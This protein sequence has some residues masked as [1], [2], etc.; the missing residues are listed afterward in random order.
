MCIR[1]SQKA[2]DPIDTNSATKEFF[3]GLNLSTDSGQIT[4]FASKVGVFYQDLAPFMGTSTEKADVFE[5][6]EKVYIS[7]GKFEDVF[8]NNMI[9]GVQLKKYDSKGEPINLFLQEPTKDH[10]NVFDTRTSY[11]RWSEDLFQIQNAPIAKNESLPSFI[12]PGKWDESYNAITLGES[13][14]EDGKDVEY[15]KFRGTTEEDRAGLNPKYPGIPVIPLRD[16]FISVP[17]IKKAF[18][19]KS[20]VNDALTFIFDK[21]T[22]DSNLVWNIKM[23]STTNAKGGITF[24]DANLMP[25]I[26][27]DEM[28]IFDVTSGETIVKTCE[29][30]FTTPKAGLSSMIAISNLN[31]PQPFDQQELSMLLSLIHI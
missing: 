16:V 28:L 10:T 9:A 12:L 18:S 1:D 6:K 21:L 5:E 22:S 19:S 2:V 20:T 4:E 11:V 24:H 13:G 30:N 29:L 3:D 27:E 14:K 8:L 17:L 31:S 23:K 7:Y 25:E 15:G 26:P